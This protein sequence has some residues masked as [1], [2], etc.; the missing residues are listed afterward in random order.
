MEA[1]CKCLTYSFLACWLILQFNN[2]AFPAQHSSS[3][4]IITLTPA[5]VIFTPILPGVPKIPIE[6]GS[7]RGV[8]KTGTLKGLSVRWEKVLGNGDKGEREEKFIWVGGR[9][10]LFARLVGW[11]GRKWVN[12]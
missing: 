6:L 3:T 4:G 2:T 10:E 9:D 7:I 11:G 8:K 5:S 12:I 1:L